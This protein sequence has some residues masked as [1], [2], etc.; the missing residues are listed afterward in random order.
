MSPFDNTFIRNTAQHSAMRASHYQEDEYY[1]D[2]FLPSDSSTFNSAPHTQAQ[3]SSLKRKYDK[4]QQELQGDHFQQ[5]QS[6]FSL[7][8]EPLLTAPR[9]EAEDFSLRSSPSPTNTLLNAQHLQQHQGIY[10][11]YKQQA[12]TLYVY[13]P[14]DVPIDSSYFVVWLSLDAGL[15]SFSTIAHTKTNSSSFGP[16]K[17]KT[18]TEE[19]EGHNHAGLSSTSP[20]SASVGPSPAT[21]MPD[22]VL[23]DTTTM[24]PFAGIT[25]LK[26]TIVDSQ[27]RT[28]WEQYQ[29]ELKKRWE[30][31]RDY[32]EQQEK[33]KEEKV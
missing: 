8:S 10:S 9:K 4:E 5:Q 18:N 14:F 20:A 32:Y 26:P 23:Q 3:V 2:P 19:Q 27:T 7:P 22:N 15:P 16:K 33:K 30:E 6:S 24:S 11:T 13:V 17:L 29:R 25:A 28:L 21:S 1:S 31:Q 12:Y